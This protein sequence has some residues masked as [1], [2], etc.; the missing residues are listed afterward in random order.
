MARVRRVAS[1]LLIGIMKNGD[2]EAWWGRRRGNPGWDTSRTPGASPQ[3]FAFS[4]HLRMGKGGWP[5]ASDSTAL[6]AMETAGSRC[7]PGGGAKP[8][9]RATK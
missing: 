2:T 5:D 1:Q 7:C 8:L 3:P 9:L 6:Q 4:S